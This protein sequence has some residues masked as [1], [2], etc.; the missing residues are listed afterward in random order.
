VG[1]DPAAIELRIPN[2]VMNQGK[3]EVIDEIVSP[4]MIEHDPPPPPFKGD[5]EGFK[6]FVRA[7]RQAFPDLHYRVDVH[8][9]SGDIVT[10]V[11]TGSGTMQG[12][13]AGM[14]AS[15]KHAEWREVHV[16]RVRDG[17]IVEHWGAVDQA[18]MLTQLGFMPEPAGA[19]AR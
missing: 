19:Q 15:G 4:D 6:A 8:E 14:P 1:A 13:F 16:S 9:A 2:E 7:F 11:A 5:I 10:T 12:D 17:K 3:V 18:G